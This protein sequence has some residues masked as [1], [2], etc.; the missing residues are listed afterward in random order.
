MRT[1]MSPNSMLSLRMGRADVGARC[2]IPTQ[3]DTNDAARYVRFCGSS[4]VRCSVYTEKF[5]TV[6][7]CPLS[8]A[9]PFRYPSCDTTTS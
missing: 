7:E 4:S 3:G 2:N 1:T 8:K 6:F 5:G 9:D